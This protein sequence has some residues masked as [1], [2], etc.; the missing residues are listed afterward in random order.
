MKNSPVEKV[1]YG[2]WILILLSSNMSVSSA[3]TFWTLENLVDSYNVMKKETTTD[4]SKESFSLIWGLKD[5]GILKRNLNQFEKY[6][7]EGNKEENYF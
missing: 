3:A 4:W 1:A 6:K 7:R 2:K 5:R